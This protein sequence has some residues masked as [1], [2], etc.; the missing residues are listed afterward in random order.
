M[1]NFVLRLV[2]PSGDGGSDVGGVRD[3]LA[4]GKALT[5]LHGEVLHGGRH[6]HVHPEA[7]VEERSV[8]KGDD[9]FI[10]VL[11]AADKL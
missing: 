9:G 1:Y 4:E 8:H 2:E 11:R 5:L 6:S 7:L 10:A 3:A